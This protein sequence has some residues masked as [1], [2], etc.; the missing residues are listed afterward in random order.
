[1]AGSSAYRCVTPVRRLEA[2]IPLARVS[3]RSNASPML[4]SHHEETE[5]PRS[6]AIQP[7]APAAGRAPPLRPPASIDIP[8]IPGPLDLIFRPWMFRH[9]EIRSRST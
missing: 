1:M 9:N 7:S 2:E 6:T 3:S 4:S 5:M 8:R